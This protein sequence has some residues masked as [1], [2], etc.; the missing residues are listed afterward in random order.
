MERDGR[1]GRDLAQVFEDLVED[2]LQV[3]RRVLVLHVGRL[4]LELVR[5]AKVLGVVVHRKLVVEVVAEEATGLVRPAPGDVA[6]GVPTAAEHQ[7]GH[8]EGLHVLQA[9]AVAADGEV[10]APE[11]VAGEGIRAGLE[12]HRIRLIHL[13]DL[14]HHRLEQRHV[15]LVVD[16]VLERDV[17]RVVLPAVLAH[18]LEVSGARKV[19]AKLVERDGHDAIGGVEGFLHAVTVVDVDVDVQYALVNLEQLED[20]EHDVVDVAKAGSLVL[21]RV[22]KATR[23]VDDG[24]RLLVVQTDRTA[25]G[26]AGVDLAE[27]EQA[28]EHRAVLG[29]VEALELPHVLVLVVGGDEAEELDVLV[30]VELGHVL[31]GRERRAKHLHLLVDAVVQK[32]VV[33]HAD[34][35]GLH[36]MTLSVVEVAHVGV[37]KV[38]D[39][40]LPAH[41]AMLRLMLS[42]R[43]GLNRAGPPGTRGACAGLSLG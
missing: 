2:A 38:R 37:V 39:L 20:R 27:V 40:R 36:R 35:V 9:L 25:H 26:A 23:P 8:V 30:A 19:L 41:G 6:D 33:G 42:R 29:A 18:V 5:G 13:H 32:E 4:D 15:G 1:F 16:A 31:G 17:D 28:V 11:P 24:V 43:V 34:T 21:L 3:L 22:V 12:H 14:R 10:E 7:E